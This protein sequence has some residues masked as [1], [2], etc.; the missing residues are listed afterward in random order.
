[1]AES[2]QPWAASSATARKTLVSWTLI[3]SMIG[4]GLV[5]QFLTLGNLAALDVPLTIPWWA[6]VLSFAA[7]G[8]LVAHVT[9]RRDAHTISLTEIPLVLGLAFATPVAL[10]AGR[11][12]GSAAALV[13]HRR[14]RPIK[15]AFNLAL[16]YLETVTAIG[17]YR[18]VLGSHGANTLA[19]WGAVL[20][21]MV[22]VQ[23]IGLSTVTMVIA[24][25]EERRPGLSSARTAVSSFVM[26]M[27]AALVGLLSVIVLWEDERSLVII[28][29]LMAG[30]YLILRTYGRLRRRSDSLSALMSFTRSVDSSLE[31]REIVR[32]TLAQ[33]QEMLRVDDAELVLRIT[34]DDADGERFSLRP[35]GSLGSDVVDRNAMAALLELVQEAKAG[36]AISTPADPQHAP[37]AAYF[38]ARGFREGLVAPIRAGGERIGIMAV[39]NRRGPR[40]R[41]NPDDLELLDAIARHTSG[42][43]N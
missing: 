18:W 5:L 16:F 42:S 34:E 27:S 9:I 14:Q 7:S 24:I 30:L 3:A 35:D 20:V 6:L 28:L 32:Q 15:L 13:L 10:V 29:V 31:T 43:L 25:N 11:L 17:V 2:R 22:V 23:V 4:I 39:G 36:L 41:F 12:V 37:A 33:G 8:V 40:P 26:S 38:S 1:M 21:A 19:G